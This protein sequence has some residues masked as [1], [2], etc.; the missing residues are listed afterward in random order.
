[1]L[2]QLKDLKEEMVEN[3]FE[4]T[5]AIDY[6]FEEPLVRN[7]KEVIEKSRKFNRQKNHLIQKI[8]DYWCKYE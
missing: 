6:F 8:K 7:K 5:E 4:L 1:M 3:F 2:N